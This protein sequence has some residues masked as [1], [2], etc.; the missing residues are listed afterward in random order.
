MSAGDCTHK[1]EHEKPQFWNFLN[2]FHSVFSLDWSQATPEKGNQN[3][4]FLMHQFLRYLQ[5]WLQIQG[6]LANIS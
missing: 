5:G 1:H 2:L 3:G 4:K 6:P